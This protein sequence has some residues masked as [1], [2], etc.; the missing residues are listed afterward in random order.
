MSEM[1]RTSLAG[2]VVVVTGGAS[3]IGAAT[4]LA[5]AAA[6]ANVVAADINSPGQEVTGVTY[7][8]ADVRDYADLEHVVE[9]SVKRFGHLDAVVAA[10]GVAGWGELAHSDPAVWPVILTTN[11]LGVAHLLRAALPT[12]IASRRGH[13]VLIASVSGRITYSGEPMYIASKWAVV[14]LGRAVRK[15]LAG[16]GVRVTLIEPGIVDTPM[17]S[18]TAQGRQE[19][20]EVTPLQP[21]DVAGAVLYALEQ[22]DRID[23]EEIMI[24][25]T[26]QTL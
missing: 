22:P 21:D 4:V 8:P 23:V 20:S 7:V 16:T 10:A 19:L 17:V 25:A 12:M 2:V 3:G 15:E 24:V 26:D 1:G 11:V 6:G 18:G 5:L 9:I 13:V 14:G